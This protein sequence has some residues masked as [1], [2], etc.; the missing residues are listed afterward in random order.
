MA[1]ERHRKFTELFSSDLFDEMAAEATTKLATELPNTTEN[2]D[3]EVPTGRM[4]P[5]LIT[6]SILF[7]RLIILNSAKKC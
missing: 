5:G 7:C 1:M 2:P 3:E 6:V 4:V